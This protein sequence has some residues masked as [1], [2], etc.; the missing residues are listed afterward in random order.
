MPKKLRPAVDLMAFN[1]RTL[2]VN[3]SKKQ[4]GLLGSML[5]GW[6]L[7]HQN[8]ENTEIH[9]FSHRQHG[10]EEFFSQENDVCAVIEALGHQ[11][12]PA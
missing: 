2:K 12:N 3:L 8:T 11:H 10:F 9:S 6:R 1:C 7:L 4:A 5:K